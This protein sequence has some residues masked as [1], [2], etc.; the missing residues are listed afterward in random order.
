M[1]KIIA[2][3]G[4][5]PKRIDD[6]VIYPLRGML[7]VRK[8]SGFTTKALR[9]SPKY[10]LCR[11]NAAEFGRVSA[12]CKALRL[13]MADFLPKN[14]NLSVVN[15]LTKQ[16]RAL[17][18]FDTQLPRGKRQLHNALVTE[19][20]QNQWKGYAFNLEASITPRC[21]VK[22]NK[23]T[24][25]TA[26]MVVP[27]DATSIGITVVRMAFHFK[28]HASSIQTNGL[29]FYNTTSLPKQLEFDLPKLKTTKGV[30]LTLVVL[31]F[32]HHVDGGFLPLQDDTNKV[33]LLADV[34]NAR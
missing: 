12:S 9:S 34:Q 22:E 30:L 16:M 3:E 17:L 23:L 11:K 1:G 20:A 21:E 29:H 25:D 19:V 7:V 14:N 28:T 15:A 8:K 18:V 32:Y 4:K 2:F 27:A 10:A 6:Y 13:A 31:D 33:V 26:T 5:I 24:L